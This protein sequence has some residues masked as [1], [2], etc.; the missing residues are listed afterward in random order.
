[1]IGD[2]VAGKA[3]TLTVPLIDLNGAAIDAT[4]VHWY[5]FDQTGAALADAVVSGF[6]PGSPDVT[7]TIPSDYLGVGE[8]VAFE[9]REIV[10]ECETDKGDKEIRD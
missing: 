2:Q 8:G 5:L 10:V 7:F 9:G 4:A 6:S 3:A 1:M